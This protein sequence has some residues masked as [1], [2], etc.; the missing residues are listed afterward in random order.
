MILVKCSRDACIHVW[1]IH[2]DWH[3]KNDFCDFLCN[4]GQDREG[5]V[6]GQMHSQK[7]PEPEQEINTEKNLNLERDLDF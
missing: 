6:C 4:S 5:R 7:T 2:Y 1:C 3:T